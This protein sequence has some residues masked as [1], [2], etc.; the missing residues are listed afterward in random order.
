MKGN[1][2]PYGGIRFDHPLEAQETANFGVPV[3]PL[4]HGHQTTSGTAVPGLDRGAAS[5][6]PT[7]RHLM[8]TC[9]GARTSRMALRATR[10]QSQPWLDQGVSA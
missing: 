7:P 3:A 2:L 5:L 4:E 10:Q 1:T 8:D 6:H 9:S